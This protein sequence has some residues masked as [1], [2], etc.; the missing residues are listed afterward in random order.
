MASIDENDSLSFNQVDEPRVG[1]FV[2]ISP[3]ILMKLP[4]FT[5]LQ[6]SH[7]I[8]RENSHRSSVIQIV[9]VVPGENKG[10][11]IR[12]LLSPSVLDIL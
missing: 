7:R 12:S 8:Q 6:N 2:V 3:T 1:T 4:H 11:R 9:V 5:M 10:S